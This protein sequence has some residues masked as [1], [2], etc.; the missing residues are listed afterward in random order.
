MAM[1]DAHGAALRSMLRRLCGRRGDAD[2]VFQETAARVWRN[3]PARQGLK[4]PRGWVMT[5]G[6]RAF[7]DARGRR[8]R[9]DGHGRYD[10]LA[11]PTA[12]RAD[13]PDHAA[14]RAEA[15]DR[16]QAAVAGLAE[17]VREVVVLHYLG[18]LSLRET[19]AAMGL[20]EG[21]VKS[22][23]NAALGRLRG[24][25]EELGSGTGPG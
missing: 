13:P 12:G 2:D 6:Y 7:V 17:P 22:R 14:E 21:T 24:A 19:A 4:N 5:I 10:E 23:L 15:F 1:L 20:S 8:R 25:L 18:G 9:E 3:L 11:D 16:V